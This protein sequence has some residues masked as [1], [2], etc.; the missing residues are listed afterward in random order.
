MTSL[1][2]CFASKDKQMF[3][4]YLDKCTKYFE[5]GSGGSTYQAVHRPNISRIYSVE[6]DVAWHT[7]LRNMIPQ[8]DRVRVSLRQPEHQTQY[9]GESRSPVFE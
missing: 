2:P 4:K 8:N 5:F 6:S 9:V 7:K 3:Y 1:E